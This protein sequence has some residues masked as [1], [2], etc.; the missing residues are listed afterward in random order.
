MRRGHFVLNVA[1]LP[2]VAS[3]EIRG[4]LFE[5]FSGCRGVSPININKPPNLVPEYRGLE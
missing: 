1:T 5:F 3:V 2:R 4:Q